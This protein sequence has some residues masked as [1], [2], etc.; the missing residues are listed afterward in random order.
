LKLSKMSQRNLVGHLKKR[1]HRRE[2]CADVS[3]IFHAASG[4]EAVQMLRKFKSKWE[5]LEP[6]AVKIFLKDIDLSLSFYGQPKEKWK[7]LASNN[8]IEREF[9]EKRRHVRLV[10]SFRDEQCCERIIFIQVLMY[11]NNQELNP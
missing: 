4:E 8:I 2:I 10:D 3:A 9:R 6:R 7:Q 1:N 11:N 5:P